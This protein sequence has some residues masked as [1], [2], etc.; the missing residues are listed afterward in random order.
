M[1]TAGSKWEQ[2]AGSWWFGESGDS[3]FGVKLLTFSGTNPYNY[4]SSKA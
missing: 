1:D 4:Y 3:A 2:F